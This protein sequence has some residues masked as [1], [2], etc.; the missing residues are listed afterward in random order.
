MSV[1]RLVVMFQQWWTRQK[2]RSALQQVCVLPQGYFWQV[3]NL[4][5]EGLLTTKSPNEVIER[6]MRK[7][8][9]YLG[10]ASDNS[11]FPSPNNRTCDNLLVSVK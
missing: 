4:L 10:R 7:D 8:L 9:R 2:K 3:D 6:K 5:A 11:N 1:V